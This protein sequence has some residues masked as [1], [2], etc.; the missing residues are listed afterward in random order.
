MPRIDFSALSVSRNCVYVV[1]VAHPAAYQPR[2]A[3]HGVLYRVIEEHLES[4]LDA[5]S[6]HA[7]GQPLPRFVEQEFG[8]FLTCGVLDHGF[9]RLRC[10]DCAFERL[11][12]FSCRRP[13]HD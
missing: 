2:T 10:G 13:A 12:P 8:D 3:E 11:V 5:A 9:A 6:Q 7:D 1:G 4:F